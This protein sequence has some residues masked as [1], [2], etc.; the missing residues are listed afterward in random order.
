MPRAFDRRQPSAD[1]DPRNSATNW[2]DPQSI[3]GEAAVNA[4]DVIR[5]N[6]VG[7]IKELTGIDLTGPLEFLDW[8]GE[9]LGIALQA[10]VNGIRDLIQGLADALANP[11][12]FL[13]AL[14][15]A[16]QDAVDSIGVALGITDGTPPDTGGVSAS[17]S[18]YQLIEEKG[19]PDGYAALDSSG[20]V[21]VDQLPAVTTPI[22]VS[23][24][25]ATISAGTGSPEAAVTAVVGS[26]YLRTDGGAGTSLYVKESGSSDTGWTAK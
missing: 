1:K 8:L 11:L 18:A 10:L 2:N 14:G 25:A 13:E 23:G 26:L 16:I 17:L 3:I 24:T 12:G 7:L 19:Q 5:D 20:T 4:G 9:Q 6:L 15:G 22:P 21:P